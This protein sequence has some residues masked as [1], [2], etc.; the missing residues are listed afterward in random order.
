MFLQAP[1][2]IRADVVAADFEPHIWLRTGGCDNG[3]LAG[4]GTARGGWAT[5]DEDVGEG[6]L[7]LVVDSLAEEAGGEFLLVLTVTPAE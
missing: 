2:N 1:A 3:L 4:C 5:L 7:T 6:L